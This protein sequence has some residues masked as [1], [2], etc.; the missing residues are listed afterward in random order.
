MIR[1]LLLATW[2]LLG[3]GSRTALDVSSQPFD[4]G[5][6]RVDAGRR[7]RVDGGVFVPSPPTRLAAGT[8][9]T[10]AVVSGGRVRCWGHNDGGQLGVPLDDRHEPLDPTDVPGIDDAVEVA[11]G[12]ESSCARHAS[13]EVSC[14]GRLGPGVEVS[15][16]TRVRGITTA[17]ELTSG[18]AHRCARLRDAT[19]VCWG[20]NERGQL[21]DGTTTRR[22]VPAPV[23]SLA[24]VEEISA[25]WDH[26][27]ART[28]DTVYC[29]GHNGEGQLGVGSFAPHHTPMPVSLAVDVVEIAAGWSHTCAR[30]GEGEV[31]CWGRRWGVE[32]ES[33]PDEVHRLLPERVASL[34]RVVEVDAG[35]AHTCTRDAEGVVACWG[36]DDYGQLG[37]G[38][39]SLDTTRPEP[40]PVS[41]LG[42]TEELV[43]GWVHNCARERSGRVLCWGSWGR[44]RGGP[45]DATPRVVAGL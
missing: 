3:C 18:S 37:T 28:T 34:A 5:P 7:D 17:V 13:G 20:L 6:A 41:A 25:G 39:G 26:S 23:A 12:R 16:P 19:V 2:L 27:C 22:D 21:G 4:A 32:S 31:Y 43:A 10:C 9:H 38:A 35:G 33:R 36:R 8:Y 1:R 11:A 15:G 45:S 14:W 24:G 29:W 44:H 40:R 42:R 30:T